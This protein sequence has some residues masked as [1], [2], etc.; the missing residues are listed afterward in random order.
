[1]YT[2]GGADNCELPPD[3]QRFNVKNSVQPGTP[4]GDAWDDLLDRLDARGRLLECP[5]PIIA[6]TVI[7]PMGCDSKI[8]VYADGSQKIKFRPFVDGRATRTNERNLGAWSDARNRQYTQQTIHE[9]ITR[10]IVDRTASVSLFDYEDFYLTMPRCRSSIP[11]NAIFWKRRGRDRP[12]VIYPMDDLFGHVTTP[13][14]VELHAALLQDVQERELAA[15]AGHPM[16]ISRRTDDSV[17]PMTAEEA[18]RAQE[19]ANIFLNVCANFNQPIQRSKVLLGVV[20]FKFD[21]YWFDLN[22]FPNNRHGAHP[23]A[24]GI[25]QRRADDIHLRLRTA[26]KG[27]TRKHLEELIGLIE[28]VATLAPHMRALLCTMRRAMHKVRQ[29][30]DLVPI[31]EEARTDMQRLMALHTKPRMTPF[32]L[33]Y[34]LTPPQVELWTDASGN[35][36]FGGYIPGDCGIFYTQK[37]SESQVLDL[38]LNLPE[39]EDELSKCTCYLELVALWYMIV[40][41]GKRLHSRVARWTTDAQASQKAWIRQSSGHH[42][43]NRLLALLSHHCTLHSIVLEARWVPREDNHLADILTHACIDQYCSLTGSNPSQQVKVP[44]RAIR[45]VAALQMR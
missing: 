44:Q 9:T 4:N 6:G 7:S 16:L 15:A 19:F 11:R 5:I 1:M 17:L 30:F 34:K 2:H 41:A 23:G 24:V 20:K 26:I 21:G 40:C 14:K 37:L 39:N 3:A 13:A 33:L 22:A 18:P 12:T 28:W 8:K 27:S 32:Y 10:F 42:A 38:E 36:H 25:D 35:D 31:D 29:D 43:T 45:K